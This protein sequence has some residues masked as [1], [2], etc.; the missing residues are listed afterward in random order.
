MRMASSGEEGWVMK[1]NGRRTIVISGAIWRRMVLGGGLRMRS[2]EGKG[3]DRLG[4]SNQG[5][6]YT[7]IDD[8]NREGWMWR[9][10][11]FKVGDLNE[12]FERIRKSLEGDKRGREVMALNSALKKPVFI[13]VDQL[14]P[15]T[16]GHTLFAKVVSLKVVLQKARPNGNQVFHVHIAESIVGDDTD[17]LVFTMRKD[18]VDLKKEGEVV[19]QK[20]EPEIEELD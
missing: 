2:R 10:L 4:R 16:S 5:Y 9:N 3:Q 15:D 20:G 12:G 7:G 11:G 1:V 8:F 19:T 17:V 14:G 6:V 13:K 18:Q